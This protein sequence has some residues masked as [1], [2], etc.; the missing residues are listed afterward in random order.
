MVKILIGIVIAIAVLNP[1]ES[2]MLVGYVLGGA[3]RML[4]SVLQL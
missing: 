1:V 2:A 3:N 4:M